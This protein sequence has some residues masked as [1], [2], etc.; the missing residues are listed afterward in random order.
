MK[1]K[2]VILAF[3]LLILNSFCV[4][5]L[6]R[7]ISNSEDWRDVYSVIQYANF[8]GVASNF[9]VSQRHSTILLYDLPA[10]SSVQV[11]TSSRYP[12]VTGYE[13]ILRG[14]GYDAEELIFDNVNLELA[15]RLT[16][17]KNFVI[18][19]DAYG[20]NAISVASYAQISKSYVLFAD[21]NN[22]GDVAAFLA[23]RGPQ[24]VIIFGYVNREVKDTLSVY[25]PEIIN[26][27]G[28]R[29]NNNIEI[30]KK[31]MELKPTKQV[32]LTNGEFIEQEIMS[33]AEPV[34]FI[35]A[36][37]VPD[38]VRDY[39]KNA[40]VEVGVLIGNQYVGTATTIKR[41]AGIS[42]FVKFARSA[43]TPDT[44][45]SPVEG[46][47]L[48]YLPAYRLN[49]EIV[50]AVYNQLT[51]Q[52][53]ITFRNN[54]D[55]ATYFLGTY[56]L[57]WGDGER[58]TV[59][60]IEP[61][62]IDGLEYRTVVYDVGPM[63]GDITANIYVIYGDSKRS[64]ENVI[65]ITMKINVTKVTDNSE[66]RIVGVVYDKVRKEFIIEVENIGNVDTYV[67]LELVDIVIAGEKFTFGSDKVTLIKKGEKKKI[68]IK[69]EL[70]E[71]DYEDNNKISVVAHYGERPQNLVK[72]LRGEFEVT[73]RGVE[74]IIYSLAPV[75]LV[76]LILIIIILVLI[77]R[78]QKKCPSCKHKNPAGRRYCEKCGAE[79]K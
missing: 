73:Y 76:L 11:V 20:Y 47:D 10:G 57:S 32:I 4:L 28:D 13:N 26:K 44:A 48:F 38:Q 16:D 64:L 46:L 7:V 45:I 49:L 21:R 77:K 40:G 15:K 2:I 25:N 67:D 60:D 50:N 68:R 62:F 79:L 65:E 18:I 19:D 9:L 75:I 23:A 54:V 31:Y 34:I 63:F 6:D 29:F 43:R 56:R 69:V 36:N 14:S 61:I 17:I 39:I 74:Y 51:N 53:E 70:D 37:N 22:I 24:K 72:I 12:F 59:G 3:L 55:L 30:V 35:G 58:Q 5:A 41:Q 71:E 78:R 27:E 33:G 52:L 42:V 1:K 8:Q 66:I